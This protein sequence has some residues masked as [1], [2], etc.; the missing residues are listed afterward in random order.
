MLACLNEC[1]Y[2]VEWR[3][4]NAADYAPQRRRRVFVYA[5]KDRARVE[6]RGARARIGRHGGGVSYRRRRCKAA[7]FAIAADPF[8]VSEHF[9]AGLKVSP[10]FARRASCR[11]AR[12]SRAMRRL[13][14]TG[15]S[16]RWATCWFPKVPFP[17]SFSSPMTSSNAG[18]ISRAP[19]RRSARMRRAIPMYTA[20]A[21]W[22]FPMRPTSRRAP[23]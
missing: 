15:R 22:R 9:G 20:K 6:S 8:E 17:R 19:K 2:A 1:G 11:A 10:L 13:S 14:T 18:S 7:S 12:C 16:P 5:E 3:V 21:A 4:V 23:F